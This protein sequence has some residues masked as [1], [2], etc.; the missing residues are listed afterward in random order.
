MKI[1]YFVLANLLFYLWVVLL[2]ADQWEAHFEWYNDKIGKA[3]YLTSSG[4]FDDHQQGFNLSCDITAHSPGKDCV[5]LLFVCGWVV[6]T[7]FFGCGGG[8]GCDCV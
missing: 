7:A 1:V 6:F 5:P 4:I 2:S 8:C 3:L